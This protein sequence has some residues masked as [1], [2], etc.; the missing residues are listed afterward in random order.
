[1]CRAQVDARPRTIQHIT[2]LAM[3]SGIRCSER[4]NS[5]SALIDVEHNQGGLGF[6]IRERNHYTGRRLM[7][8]CCMLQTYRQIINVALKTTI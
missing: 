6:W 4:Q 7:F 1:M 2:S 5:R 3:S 8:L